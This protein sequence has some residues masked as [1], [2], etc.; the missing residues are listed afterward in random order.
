MSFGI[1]PSR[2]FFFERQKEKYISSDE[3]ATNMCQRKHHKKIR[4]PADGVGSFSSG[5]HIPLMGNI[6]EQKNK[7][8]RGTDTYVYIKLVILPHIY[9]RRRLL[10]TRIKR[11]STTTILSSDSDSHRHNTRWLI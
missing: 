11:T 4:E 8:K 5:L 7:K 2:Y 3:S 1:F 10:E 9:N 6:R